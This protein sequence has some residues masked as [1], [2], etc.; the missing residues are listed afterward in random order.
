[1]EHVEELSENVQENLAEQIAIYNRGL[2]QQ[3]EGHRSF[4]DTWRDLPDLF[5]EMCDALNRIRHGSHPTPP[6]RRTSPWG[7]RSAKH[8]PNSAV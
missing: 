2:E 3:T 1:M 4:A 5:D 8:S 7:A 6:I